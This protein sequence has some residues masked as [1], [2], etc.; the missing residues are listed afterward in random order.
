MT[1]LVH[2]RNLNQKPLP[3]GPIS[4][5][6]SYYHLEAMPRIGG[7]AIT[8]VSERHCA[9]KLLRRL[10]R[11][12][13][14]VFDPIAQSLANAG[15]AIVSR[16]RMSALNADLFDAIHML[17]IV[18]GS[19]PRNGVTRTLAALRRNP[20]TPVQRHEIIRL[21]QALESGG[22]SLTQAIDLLRKSNPRLREFTFEFL[23][24]RMMREGLPIYL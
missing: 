24:A 17:C 4:T 8:L 12:P 2:L 10:G 3:C 13:L 18:R 20:D 15:A 11:D 7:S 23:R 14:P 1:P 9:E 6:G 19:V 22:H 21:A 5:R 16:L